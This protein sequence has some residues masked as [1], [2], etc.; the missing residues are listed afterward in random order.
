MEQ[1]IY[2]A[3]DSLYCCITSQSMF[4][5]LPGHPNKHG[6]KEDPMLRIMMNCPTITKE[7]FESRLSTDNL[8]DTI[9]K[10]LY[11]KEIEIN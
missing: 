6:S 8:L 2:K 7:Q 10:A 5:T 9:F 4:L 1:P 3:M 11:L